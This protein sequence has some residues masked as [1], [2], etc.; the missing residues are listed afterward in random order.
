MGI[1]Y[2]TRRSNNALI[3]LSEILSKVP[4][5]QVDKP[6]TEE[7]RPLNQ[8][9]FRRGQDHQPRAEVLRV[10]ASYGVVQPAPTSS[11]YTLLPRTR[12]FDELPSSFA[13]MSRNITNSYFISE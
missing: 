12:S 11:R 7:A 13:N 8:L 9:H 3:K 1:D 2:A 6:K 5:S 10:A 4:I